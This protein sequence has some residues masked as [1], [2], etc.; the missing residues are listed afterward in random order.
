MGRP[1]PMPMMRGLH[2]VFTQGDYSDLAITCGD[3]TWKAHRLVLCTQS[4]YFRKACNG[5]FAETQDRKIDLSD[6][7]VHV[8][9]TMLHYLYH[10]DYDDEH[11]FVHG[12][13][14]MTLNICMA[15][16]ADKYNVQPLLILACEKLKGRVSTHWDTPAFAAAISLA[17]GTSS[18]NC[19]RLRSIVL[20]AAI[21]H[22]KELFHDKKF[23]KFQKAAR[24]QTD[25]C[26]EYATAVSAHAA[27]TDSE[28]FAVKNANG[29]TWFK[30]R[31][32]TCQKHEGLFR[33]KMSGFHP[34]WKLNCPMK[35]DMGKG[36][37]FWGE[38]IVATDEAKFKRAKKNP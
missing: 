29:A 5:P 10:F 21:L 1:V 25:F 9:A 37:D 7:D 12:H 13:D 22:A 34:D 11:H 28:K 15:L 20:G 26:F 27:I 2:N 3:R 19:K 36:M 18:A 30:C 33:V 24:E 32:E 8:L 38:H 35:C 17:F 4:E 31:G 23:E 14:A 6:D 16:I